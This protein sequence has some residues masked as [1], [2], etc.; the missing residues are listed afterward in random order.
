MAQRR[1]DERTG[2]A[3]DKSRTETSGSE[4]PVNNT[5]GGEEVSAISSEFEDDMRHDMEAALL[6]QGVPREGDPGY[7]DWHCNRHHRLQHQ[8]I[9]AALRIPE[10]DLPSVRSRGA[11]MVNVSDVVHDR[12]SRETVRIE[13]SDTASSDDLIE[14]DGRQS[15]MG[16]WYVLADMISAVDGPEALDADFDPYID[17][18]GDQFDSLPPDEI[19][20][21]LLNFL[22]GQDLVGTVR[23][24]MRFRSYW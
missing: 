3:S 18:R 11:V 17:D 13:L 5:T 9:K 24:E 14:R 16:I 4:P 7:C 2:A 10:K 1:N 20:A 22:A 12:I 23:N 15:L 8:V 19:R 6:D 21:F